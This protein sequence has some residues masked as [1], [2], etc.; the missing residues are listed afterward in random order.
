MPWLPVVH[1]PEEDQAFFRGTVL[2]NQSVFVA[3][4]AGQVI[5]FVAYESD[6]LNHLYVVPA[7]FR[8]GI[9]SALLSK[10]QTDA[11]LLQLWVFQQNY[12]ARAFYF[13]HGF[14]E[15]EFT[16]GASNEE[17]TPDVRMIWQADPSP[18]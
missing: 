11:N 12:D 13:R 5:G 16:D 6:W 1:T 10:A 8:R 17:K 9:G 15:V 3:E 7:F 18:R 14:T 4:T 2:S